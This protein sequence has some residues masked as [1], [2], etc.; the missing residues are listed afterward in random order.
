[1]TKTT[2][3]TISHVFCVEQG[4]FNSEI[5]ENHAQMYQKKSTLL[6]LIFFQVVKQENLE[7][8]D[9]QLRPERL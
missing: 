5:D 2:I 7:V 1:M 8:V 3:E 6:L 4:S 9:M